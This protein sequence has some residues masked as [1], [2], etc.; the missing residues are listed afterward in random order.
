MKRLTVAVLM[1][2]I[3]AEREISLMSGKAIIEALKKLGKYQIKIYDP[4]TD[5]LRLFCDKDKIDVALPI[6]HGPYGEDGTIQGFLELCGIPY[7]FSRVLPS[8]LGINKLLQ[9][10]IY[11]QV[12]LSVPKYQVI[13]GRLE[14]PSLSYPVVVK[15]NTQGSSV[16][17]SICRNAEEYKKGVNEAL[18]YDQTVLVEEYIKGREIT[19]G[20]VGEGEET[21]ALPVIEI[22]PKKEFFNYQAKYNGTTEEI[23]PAPLPPE[24]SK[25]AQ[26][27]AILCHKTLGCSGVTRIDM[28]LDDKGK[29]GFKNY[30]LEI[31]TIPGFTKESLIPKAA[32]AAGI[33][34]EEL[35]EKIIKIA[36]K[37]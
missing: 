33:K 31:N 25:N 1:G 32:K 5:L 24:I 8:A 30:I 36:L 20:V 9:R 11:E 14:P 21:Y 7:G 28:I 19:V 3:S 26:E 12:G 27:S 29:N 2:G 17:V 23:V 13:Q 10:K 34:F 16:G 4:K 22:I 6:L 35:V 18:K 15:P 37:K